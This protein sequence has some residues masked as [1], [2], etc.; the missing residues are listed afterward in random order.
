MPLYP[1]GLVFSRLRVAM[2]VA[3]RS[4]QQVHEARRDAIEAAARA[5]ESHETA[6]A[7]VRSFQEEVRANEIALKGVETEA[8]VGTRIVLDI[9]DAE[10]EL[11]DAQVNLVRSQ[12]DEIVAGYELKLAV[13]RLTAVDLG[14][15]VKI[16]DFEGYY[17]SVRDKWFGAPKGSD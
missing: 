15:P 14:L 16:Y 10:Q 17:R 12:R 5:W 7:R 4:R 8:L 13:G 2:Y 9:L 1:G 6:R 3:S 11:L